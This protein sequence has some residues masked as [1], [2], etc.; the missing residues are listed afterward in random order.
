MNINVREGKVGGVG[1]LTRPSPFGSLPKSGLPL[2]VVRCLS[3]PLFF[4]HC[5]LNRSWNDLLDAHASLGRG[6]VSEDCMQVAMDN[7]SEGR[8]TAWH[9]THFEIS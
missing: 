9:S 4:V 5:W 2:R 7:G 8:G 3:L 6:I 1:L